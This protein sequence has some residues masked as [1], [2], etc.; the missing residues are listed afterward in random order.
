MHRSLNRRLYFKKFDPSPS[1]AADGIAKSG[2]EVK[3]I[4]WHDLVGSAPN[5]L[6]ARFHR[7]RRIVIVSN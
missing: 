1:S 7:K 6:D 3:N 4:C 5:M 2:D